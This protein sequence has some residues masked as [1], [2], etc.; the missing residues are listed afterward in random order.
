[1]RL[2]LASL[3]LLS[4]LFTSCDNED[5]ENP[6]DVRNE[7]TSGAPGDVQLFPDN[8][9]VVI[10]WIESGIEGIEAYQI[11]RRYLA[12]E[13]VGQITDPDPGESIATIEAN[14]ETG[15]TYEFVDDGNG[16]GLQNDAGT[17]V[18]RLAYVSEGLV[19]PDPLNP[20]ENWPIY[21]V[22]PSTPPAP[23]QLGQPITLGEPSDLELTLFWADYQPPLDIGSF[24]IYSGSAGSST[25][26]LELADTITVDPQFPNPT[27]WFFT[28]RFEKDGTVRVYRIA[29]VDQVGVESASPTFEVTSPNLPPAAPSQIVDP[30]IQHPFSARY[31]VRMRWQAS[32]LAGRE[33]P[34]LL[35][36]RVYGT[37]YDISNERLIWQKRNTLPR[38][39][40]SHELLAEDPI[41]FE[42][43][44]YYRDYYIVAY[45]D[46]PREDGS[47]DESP[48]P[49]LPELVPPQGP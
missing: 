22:T 7:R 19:N 43:N 12:P 10:R 46:T 1:M 34:D 29:A 26:Q 39:T 4:V 44:L 48:L 20:P 5:F 45:D 17:Y 47:D 25:R 31:D 49:P 23:L 28:D 36:Y 42:G 27:E 33:T 24:R 32:L 21:P 37:H 9:Q 8:A 16:N 6:L 18:Y 41:A 35:G 3:M 15:Q 2:C 14:L 38:N 11:F 30:P 13:S 40:F